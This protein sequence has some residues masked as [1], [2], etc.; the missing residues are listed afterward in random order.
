MVYLIQVI[1][2]NPLIGYSNYFFELAGL[3][4]AEAF[5]MGVGTNAI[6]FLAT[7]LTFVV[8]SYA[9]RRFIYNTGLY[10]MTIILFIIAILDCAPGYSTNSDFS[11]AQASLL[12]VWTFLYQLT[13][14]PLTFVII[15]EVSSTKLRSRTIAIAT[16]AQATASIVTT[17]AVPFMFNPQ[18]GNLRGKIAFVFGGLSVISAIWCYFRLPETQHRTFEEIDVMFERKVRTKEFKNYNAFEL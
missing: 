3:N 17:V 14:G 7:C 11:W 2:G 16:A 12:D 8:L 5:N 1:C 18:N 13:V 15:S 10:I 6:G 4:P 9:G